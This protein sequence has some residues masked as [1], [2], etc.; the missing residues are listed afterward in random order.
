MVKDDIS[1]TQKSFT[2]LEVVGMAEE[3]T[4]RIPMKWGIVILVL[5]ASIVTLFSITKEYNIAGVVLGISLWIIA[6]VTA[7][8]IKT[9]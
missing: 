5:L 3:K 1:S 7:T 2:K 6:I 9:K 8:N 4:I